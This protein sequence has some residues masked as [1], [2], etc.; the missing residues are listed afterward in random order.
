MEQLR[1]QVPCY[2]TNDPCDLRYRLQHLCFFLYLT[3]KVK[4]R[5]T[6]LWKK[7]RNDFTKCNHGCMF[8]L[9]NDIRFYTNVQI[10]ISR[11]LQRLLELHRLNAYLAWIHKYNLLD[12]NFWLLRNKRRTF[13]RSHFD[14][15][16]LIYAD[17]N[18]FLP[19]NFW[20]HLVHSHYD[21]NSVLRPKSF[22]LLLF[23]ANLDGFHH[24]RNS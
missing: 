16:Y 23:S 3:S 9:S 19:K 10:R 5:W 12:E 18:L 8:D 1:L 14:Y 17:Q 24:F 15:A 4:Q 20:K 2:R 13:W 22:H 7:V 11:I 6:S 21:E